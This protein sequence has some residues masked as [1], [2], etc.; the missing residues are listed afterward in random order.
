M[1]PKLLPSP[2]M[3][4]LLTQLPL[5]RNVAL[6]TRLTGSALVGAGVTN[7]S[8]VG[9]SQ[10]KGKQDETSAFAMIFSIALS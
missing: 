4:P 3:Q 6:P 9:R 10:L 5:A 8:W 2:L 7:V 1:Q